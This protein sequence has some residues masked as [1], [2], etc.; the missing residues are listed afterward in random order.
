[1]DQTT[2][3]LLN[4]AAQNKD[5]ITL[6]VVAVVIIVPL[7]LKVLG[8]KVPILDTILDLTLK[9]V[10]VARPQKPLPPPE[11]GKPEGVAA[12]VP[13]EGAKDQNKP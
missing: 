8:K 2:I 5:W 6:A 10:R 7:V 9:I 12:I 1:M 4:Q 11:P 3:D 13:I